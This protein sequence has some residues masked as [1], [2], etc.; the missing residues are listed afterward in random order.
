MDDAASLQGL[1]FN[2]HQAIHLGSCFFLKL[3]PAEPL[4]V[5]LYTQIEDFFIFSFQYPQA[6]AGIY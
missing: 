5:F 4:L 1:C 2:N 3:E 6:L